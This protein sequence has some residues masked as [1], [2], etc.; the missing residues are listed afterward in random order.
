M[1]LIGGKTCSSCEYRI[2]MNN[3]MFCGRYPPQIFVVPVVDPIA[4]ATVMAP[5]SSYPQV[6]PQLPC[7]EYKR[8]DAYAQ[9]EVEM[10]NPPG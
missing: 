3:R 5:Q 1:P 4:K 2:A 7:G 6:N 8:N 10:S 9:K